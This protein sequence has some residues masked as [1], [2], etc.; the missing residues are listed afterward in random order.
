M[1]KTILSL[2][3]T[4][5]IVSTQAQTKL[6]D[7]IVGE[8][9]NVTAT[10][11]LRK[12]SETGKVVTVISK[13]QIEKSQ[14]KSLTQ[15]LNEQV[16][17][18]I[19]GALNNAGTNQSVFMRGANIGRTLILLDGIPVNDPSLINN[20]FDLNLFALSNVESIEICKGGQST[21]YGSDAVAGVINIITAKNDITKPFQAAATLSAGS[22]NTIKSNVQ[23]YGTKNKFSY[24][25]KAGNIITKGFSSAYDSTGNKAYDNDKYYSNT[26]SANVKYNLSESFAVKAFAQ[27]SIYNTSIDAGIFSDE[28][29]YTVKNNST[30]AGTGFSFKKS[31]IS[32]TGNYQYS[33]IKRNY[34]ND[35]IDKPGFSKFVTDDYFGKN[36]FVEL[37]ANINLGGGF[38]LLQGADFRYNNMNSEYY[39]LSSFGPYA[40]ITKDSVQSQASV[41]ASLY[42]KGKNNKFTTEVGGRLNVHS[43]Y[44]FNNTYTINP[45][46]QFNKNI[47]AFGSLSTGFKA[48]SLYQ[49]YSSYGN[50]KLKAEESKNVE[51]GVQHNSKYSVSRIVYF[52]RAINNGID[53]NNISFS[54]F[55]II[56]QLVS[57]VE[58][59]T[60]IKPTE[61]LAISINYTGLKMEEK[62]QS[63]VTFKDTTYEQ[64][65]RRPKN[66]LNANIAYQFTKQLYI[67]VSGKAVGARYDVGGYKKADIKLDSYFLLGAYAEYQINKNIKT[68]VDAQNIGNVKFFDVRGYNSIPFMANVGVSFKW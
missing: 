30:I 67:S 58:L 8:V 40:S 62:S 15:L 42:Y 25:L 38:S 57:G 19:A 1:K 31:I 48:P 35:S 36:Q 54:Y 14:G 3:A 20:E 22:F 64:L 50:L 51:V 29:D 4:L 63:R 17:V 66:S 28:K 52:N 7:T 13:A 45:S 10:K 11:T 21:L 53:F 27:K 65:L 6:N 39:S 61:K 33:D 9:A 68:F 5:L 55:N 43:R 23:L 34:Y 2:A 41:F 26:I 32:L 16:G 59:E 18:T 47:R 44:G 24:T 12:Q 37:Y 56:K 49:L 60:T 46:Y